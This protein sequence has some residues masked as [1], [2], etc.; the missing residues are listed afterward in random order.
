V[1]LKFKRLRRGTSRPRE[2]LTSEFRDFP[3][4]HMQPLKPPAGE[5]W[6]RWAGRRLARHAPANH[7]GPA[8][9]PSEAI[10]DFFSSDK[11]L[12]ST[13]S[14]VAR[15]YWDMK[16]SAS[17]NGDAAF[18]RGFSFSCSLSPFSFLLSYSKLRS[19]RPHPDTMVCLAGLH[20]ERSALAV[21]G[22]H[23]VNDDRST[24]GTGQ[25]THMR[26]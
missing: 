25:T 4:Q 20:S 12:P 1:R 5:I 15:A 23:L 26:N 22:Y 16:G 21:L 11:V 10:Q 2:V 19:L 3:L 24:I 9:V 17:S 7:V 8:H 18:N 6:A 14:A 13:R